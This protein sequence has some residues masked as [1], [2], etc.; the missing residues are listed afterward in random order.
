LN[1]RPLTYQIVIHFLAIVLGVL[2]VLL[3]EENK[4]LEALFETPHEIAVGDVFSLS[5]VSPISMTNPLKGDQAS[6]VFLFTT[7]CSYCRM[8]KLAW[9]DVTLLVEG[10]GVQV[11]GIS[12]DTGKQTVEF[13][14]DSVSYPV[15]VANDP[16]DFKQ[17]NRITG[18]P[19]TV[20]LSQSGTVEAIWTGLFL[21][22]DIA[23]ALSFISNK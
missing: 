23:E 8:N 1:F 2:V 12:L 16:I 14:R 13:V 9:L 10:F 6:L 11:V 15:Y 3:I 5:G 17:R 21:S 20:L 19:Q 18:V 22:E 7:E 4:R